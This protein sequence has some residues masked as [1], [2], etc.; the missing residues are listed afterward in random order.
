MKSKIRYHANP[1]KSVKTFSS[2]S[3]DFISSNS[4]EMDVFIDLLI[5]E[6]LL[7]GLNPTG[8]LDELRERLRPELE[9]EYKLQQHLKKVAHC[10]KLAQEIERILNTYILGDEDGPAQ[11]V[12]PMDKDKK[13][14]E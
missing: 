8:E 10:T 6:L 13:P 1:T 14:L 9:L 7:R 4:D 5:N 2:T 11:W 3:I 12:L